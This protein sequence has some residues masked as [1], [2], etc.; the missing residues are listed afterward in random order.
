MS[1]SNPEN[2]RERYEMAMIIGLANEG[3]QHG[4]RFR[5]MKEKEVT[6]SDRYSLKFI[7]VCVRASIAFELFCA[8]YAKPHEALW[9]VCADME[10]IRAVGE[11]GAAETGGMH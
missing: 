4:R 11:Y 1:K 9:M 5:R 8:F 3:I 10:M 2:V 7:S 6:P